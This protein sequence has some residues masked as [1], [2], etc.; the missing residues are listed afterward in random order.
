MKYTA[1]LE[2]PHWEVE[3]GAGRE[4]GRTM[5]HV[6]GMLSGF[7]AKAKLVNSNQNKKNGVLINSTGVL[8][9]KCMRGRPW[10]VR[11]IADHKGC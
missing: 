7:Q 2:G 1:C 5:R 10:E 8:F 4:R 9:K 6:A 11:E 3:A